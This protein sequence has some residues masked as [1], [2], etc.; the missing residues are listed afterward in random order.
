MPSRQQAA[1]RPE[2]MSD[3]E[4]LVALEEIRQ[5]K[6]RRDRYVDAHDW[7]GYASLHAPDH[8]SH[9][10][11]DPK[12]GSA[13]K[14]WS[15]SE[16]IENT[17]KHMPESLV[18]AHHSYDPE[19]SFE[20]PTRARAIWAMTAATVSTDANGAPSW[21]IGYG[22]YFETYEKRDGR[23]LFTSRRWQRHFGVQSTQG[24]D[25]IEVSFPKTRL[26]GSDAFDDFA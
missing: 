22:Y 3:I 25:A 1:S 8:V 7:D 16:M 10:A 21:S 5:L 19:F 15:V 11:P 9:H 23:W 13:P 12:L 20:T 6:A 4:W 14:P 24:S 17:R 2:T 18:S 26:K